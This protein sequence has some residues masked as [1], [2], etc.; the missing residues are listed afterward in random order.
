MQIPED[1]LW[2][3]STSAYQFEG[4]AREDGK[5]L[6]V[7][8]VKENPTGDIVIAMDH[9][10]RYK[11]DVRLLAELGIHAYRFSISWSRIL[12]NG[13][14]DVN[15][16]GI[17][18]YRNL[19]NE[20]KMYNIKPVVTMYHDDLPYEL[21]KNGGW[22]NRDIVDDFVNYA[23][24][25][26]E[27][28]GAD[29]AYFQPICE[30]NLLT[31]EQIVKQEKTLRQIF[32][33]NHHMFLAQAKVFRLYHDMKLPG[34]IGPALNVVSVYPYSSD[35]KDILAQK[36]MECIRQNMYLDVACYGQYP[37]TAL[38]LLEKLNACPVFAREDEE[39]LRNGTCDYLSF[40]T[41]T[42]LTVTADS[43]TH[44]SFKDYTNMKYGF[45]IPGLF[46]IVPNDN[47]GYTPFEKEVDPIGTRI[48]LK[49]VYERY[50][51]PIL[52][53]QRGYGAAETVN[54]GKINDE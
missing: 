35:P 44:S 26:F 15:P 20:L 46:K 43:D 31:I 29:V 17:S 7:Q 36:Y 51:K 24:I 18:F 48:I 28:F 49:D 38:R 47:L 45:N 10:H 25:L 32:Q 3:V 21:Q 34:K 12:P 11:E 23:R 2:A 22:G 42:S 8:D 30:Q 4:V 13:K 54:G 6:S 40:S 41:Y 14:G 39:I 19:I 27:Q 33:E 52:S 37:K 9:Y 16:K 5:G 1:F 50:R 53:I